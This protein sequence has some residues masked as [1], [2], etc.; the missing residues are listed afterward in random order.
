MEGVKERMR[1]EEQAQHHAPQP[2]KNLHLPPSTRRRKGPAFLPSEHDELPPGV[3]FMVSSQ[4]QLASL[5]L[6]RFLSDSR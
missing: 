1:F 5:L 2:D 3:A 4:V 6:I